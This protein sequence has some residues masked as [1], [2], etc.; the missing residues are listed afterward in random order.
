MD[1]GKDPGAGPAGRPGARP[2]RAH[3]HLGGERRAAG[4][5]GA[6]ASA[7]RRRWS[8]DGVSLTIATT[9]PAPVLSALAERD[10]LRGLHGARAPR[11][12]TCSSTSPDGSTGHESTRGLGSLSHGDAARLRPGPDGAVL[13]DPVPADVP[14]AL[15]RAVQGHRRR[16]GSTCCRSARCR[17]STRCRPT[18]GPSSTRSSRCERRDDARGRVEGGPRGRRRGGDRAAGRHGGRPLLGGRPGAGRHRPHDRSTRWWRAPTWRES[19]VPP[20]FSLWRRSRSR[21]SRCK[22]IQFITPGLLGWAVA[23][24]AMFGAA[25][26]LVHLAAEAHP[27]PAAAGPGQPGG[28][29]GGPGR[30][31]PADRAGPDRHLHRRGAAA[32]TSGCSC[33]TYWWMAI[34][35][36]IAGTLAFL[37]IGL[38]AGAWAKTQESASAVVN[39]IVLPMAFLSGSF[40]P[41]DSAPALAAHDLAGLPAQ[42]PQRRD[43]RRDGAGGAR[44][45]RCCRN[46]GSCSGSPW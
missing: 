19:G 11:W 2:G 34:P 27:A 37:S 33:T 10:A 41:L 39:I 44:P 23:T 7:G 45:T 5:G 25:L 9:D 16:R 14:G 4:R 15:R 38:L 42:A 40:F 26:T 20:R 29:G 46:W 18:R 21:T 24:G 8:D 28:G 1:H 17:C 31:Q 36:I 3:P 13:H 32:R 30:H 12:R 22:T 35:L 43:A 6:G